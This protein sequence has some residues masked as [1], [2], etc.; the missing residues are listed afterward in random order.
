MILAGD[1]GGTKSYLGIFKPSDTERE[2]IK[3]AE[4]K[5]SSKAYEKRGFPAMVNDFLTQAGVDQA[6]LTT[7]C[8]GVAGAVINGHCKLSNLDLEVD[9]SKLSQSLNNVPVSVLNDMETMGLG[10]LMLTSDQLTSLNLEAQFDDES[11]RRRDQLPRAV[12][13]AGTGLG[14][15]GLIWH[16]KEQQFYPIASEGGH[17]SFAPIKDSQIELWRYLYKCKGFSDHVSHER[18]LSGPGLFNIYQF[19][20]SNQKY[21]EKYGREN[22]YI[23]HLL[24][25]ESIKKEEANHAAIISK[26]A[27]ATEDRYCEKAL[28]IFVSIYGARAGS[29]ALTYKALGGVYLGGGIAPKILGSSIASEIIVKKLREKFMDAFK[30]KG[31]FTEFVSKIPVYVILEPKIG[32]LG[33]AYQARQLASTKLSKQ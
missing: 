24:F 13:A 32:L 31:R 19:V 12:I 8:F 26:V 29:L 14:E 21:R 27:L 5:Y 1:I 4:S 11:N 6:K 33:A 2:L 28:D 17:S 3:V 9:E 30:K 18:V 16:K 15:V 22:R 7:T 25:A 23:E 10:T 20:T